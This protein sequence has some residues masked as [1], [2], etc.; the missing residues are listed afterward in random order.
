M[1]FVTLINVVNFFSASIKLGLIISIMVI[2]VHISYRILNAADLGIEGIF[3][4]GGCIC[5]VLISFGVPSIIAIFA[6]ILCGALGGFIT[7]I[8]HTKLKIPM[9]LSGIITLT[10]FYSINLAILG[11]T[12]KTSLTLA[13]L[14][15]KPQKSIF[16]G[17]VNMFN[18][19]G[20][21]QVNSLTLSTMIISLVILA[22]VIIGIYF[23]FGTEL[24]MAIRAT[25][26]NP[27]MAKAQGINTDTMI[28]I[29]L[30]IS[31]ALIALAG[32]LFAQNS[33]TVTVQ[34]GKG[35]IVVGLASIIIAEAIFGRRSYKLQL[36]SLVVGAIIYYLLRQ[37]AITLNLADFLDLAS[38]II[39]TIIL[40]IPL[41]KSAFKKRQ[42]L[43][44]VEI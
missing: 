32:A 28:I 42:N 1:Q 14:T 3:P 26:D 30:I 37:L 43:G 8:L 27:Q 44:K 33:G 9:I 29:G 19:L 25:G 38:A 23:F 20:F 31:N 7:A 24:G 6:S 21:K 15:I 16:F 11:I 36:I 2:G 4:L 39:I 12:S 17:F 5:A 41:I 22:I 40:A 13:S 18:N 35:M 34:N 10:G